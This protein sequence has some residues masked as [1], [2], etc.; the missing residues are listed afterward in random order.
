VYSTHLYASSAVSLIRAHDPATPLFLYLAFQAVHSPD[1]VPQ[2]YIDPYNATIA[3]PKR[4]TFAGMLSCLD[5]AVGNV[6][7]ALRAAGMLDNTVIVLVSDNGG[8]TNLDEGTFSNNFPLRG[9][10]HSLWEG[11]TR[12]T[13]LVAGARTAGAGRHAISKAASVYAYTAKKTRSA[14]VAAAAPSEGRGV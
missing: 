4:R 8:P 9:G 13:A 2:Q 5:E 7:A 11:G 12:L 14:R 3:D 10:K 1:Q 6:T